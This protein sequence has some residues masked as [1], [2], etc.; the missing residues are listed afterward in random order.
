ME[1]ARVDRQQ[2]QKCQIQDAYLAL[3][4]RGVWGEKTGRKTS[5]IYLYARR[6]YI[7]NQKKS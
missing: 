5:H 7:T 1:D 4:R 2:L 6:R 3:Q